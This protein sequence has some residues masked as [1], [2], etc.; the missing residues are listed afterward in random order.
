MNATTELLERWYRG[1]RAALDTLLG[2]HLG[3]IRAKAH[4]RLGP[5]LRAKLESGDVVQDALIRFLQQ[6]PHVVVASAAQFRGLM[7]RIVEN[8]IRDRNDW[9]TARRRDLRREQDVPD[10]SVIVIDDGGLTMRGAASA[11]AES[12]QLAL[13]RLALEIMDPDDRRIVV[14]RR[15][16]A[17]PHSAI[18]AE[19]GINEAASSMRYQRA[20]QRLASIVA[21]L[22]RQGLR[23]LVEADGDGAANS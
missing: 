17:L 20:M 10:E 2:Q 8:V 11:C 14:M 1:D 23:G 13:I 6:G 12:E 15:F 5:E 4:A 7:M 9:F 21:H 18:A 16:D 22:Q 19:F 3:W